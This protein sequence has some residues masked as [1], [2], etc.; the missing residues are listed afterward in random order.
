MGS[1]TVRLARSIHQT[2]RALCQRTVTIANCVLFS[3]GFRPGNLSGWTTV[4]GLVVQ[5]QQVY[6][7]LY[8][9]RATTSGPATNASKLFSTA[10]YELY[11]STWFKILSLD[12][13]N[14]V[15]LQR[16]IKAD[17]FSAVG[18]FVSKTGKL[19][20]RN[21]IG[22]TSNTSATD[23]SPVGTRSRRMPYRPAGGPARSRSGSTA[24][25]RQQPKRQRAD[26]AYPVATIATART[27]DVAFGVEVTTPTNTT[28]D[29]TISEP[30][31]TNNTS[32]SFSFSQGE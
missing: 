5:Q 19:G 22:A 30:T 14:S 9:V 8:A 2:R 3:G 24:R 15:Y 17:T 32:A 18:V 4:N 1:A 13:D 27:Y 7:G 29:T 23:V 11:Y 12:P 10:Q 16:F 25:G 6:A 20:Y 28:A 26:R 21:D 31:L